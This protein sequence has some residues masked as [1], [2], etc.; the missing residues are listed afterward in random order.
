M[1]LNLRFFVSNH[2]QGHEKRGGKL[3]ECR[4]LLFQG[5]VQ[6][7]KLHKCKKNCESILVSDVT[8][9]M[10]MIFCFVSEQFGNYQVANIQQKQALVSRSSGCPNA[11]T[12]QVYYVVPFAVSMLFICT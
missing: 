5:I 11:I 9:L 1:S 8:M 10:L 2:R 4:G 12:F 3:N 6:C 7:K